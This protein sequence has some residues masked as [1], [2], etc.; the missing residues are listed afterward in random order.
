[1]DSRR[2]GRSEETVL[3]H[4]SPR[5]DLWLWVN[6]PWGSS[7]LRPA[8]KSKPR[9]ALSYLGPIGQERD[10][11]NHNNDYQHCEGENYPIGKERSL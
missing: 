2:D 3:A 4:T 10:R 6:L 7:V 8:T 9:P 1:M 11:D 5:R